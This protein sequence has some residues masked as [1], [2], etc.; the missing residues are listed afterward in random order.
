M[1]NM[2]SYLRN[3]V[4]I[5]LLAAFTTNSPWALEDTSA[6]ENL[7]NTAWV[8]DLDKLEALIVN[9]ADVKGD[10]GGAVLYDAAVGGKYAAVEMLIAHGANV[11]YRESTN[12][13]TPL[14]RV[15]TYVSYKPLY[16]MDSFGRNKKIKMSDG[17]P[18][19]EATMAQDKLKFAKLLIAHGADINARSMGGITPLHEVST[20]EMAELLIKHGADVNAQLKGNQ[21]SPLDSTA[22]NFPE[23]VD[24]LIAHG[25]EVNSKYL[26]KIT[27][28]H[29]AVENDQKTIVKLL[30]KRGADV[31]AKNENGD[32]P[33]SIAVRND[34]TELAALVMS[35]DEQHFNASSK[36]GL[37]NLNSALRQKNVAMV[38][39]LLARDFKIRDIN[40][41]NLPKFVMATELARVAQVNTRDKNGQVPLE[42]ALES[43]DV[44]L[45]GRLNMEHALQCAEERK[46]LVELLIQHGADVNANSRD[47]KSLLHLIKLANEPS[48]VGS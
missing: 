8:G 43:F 4:F 7:L 16:Q 38:K 47:G 35:N 15:V 19:M 14:H 12:G 44:V 24:T 37:T 9:G 28:L 2:L 6:Y 22:S 40:Q 27:S 17:L 31:L 32:T 36:N 48:R 13:F 33:L 18:P 20:R 10:K 25:A 46:V 41:Y 3:F 45:N 42:Y 34:N 5:C 30:I 1:S 21:G 11:N 39:L 26:A 29:R 23:V